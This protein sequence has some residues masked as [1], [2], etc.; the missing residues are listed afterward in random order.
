MTLLKVIMQA[1]RERK[2]PMFGWSWGDTISAKCPQC[3]AAILLSKI[4]AGRQSFKC[5][6]CGEA[7][8]WVADA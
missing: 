5:P 2:L 6:A 4:E 3:H 1:I 7:A 8:T